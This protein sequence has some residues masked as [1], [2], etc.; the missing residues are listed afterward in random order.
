MPFKNVIPD[1]VQNAIFE[2]NKSGI[3][4]TPE[5]VEAAESSAVSSALNAETVYMATSTVPCN[6][7]FGANPTASGRTTYLAANTIY[8]FTVMKTTKVAAIRNGDNS[9]YLYMTP[10]ALDV[11]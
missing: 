2:R 8:F 1:S 10:M 7:A 9:G 11:S 4:G 3:P 5:I 6:I